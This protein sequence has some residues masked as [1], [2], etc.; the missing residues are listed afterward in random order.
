MKIHKKTSV[1]VGILYISA[2]FFLSYYL[3]LWQ[4][5]IFYVINTYTFLTHMEYAY[6]F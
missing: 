1:S 2:T 6:H 5:Q 3:C 4:Y